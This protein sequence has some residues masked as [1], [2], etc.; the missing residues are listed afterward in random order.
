VPI[1]EFECGAC[2]ERFEELVPAGEDAPCPAC[3]G[4][5]RRVYSP[6]TTLKMGPQGADAR[7]SNTVRRAREE[8]KREDHAAKRE[9]ESGG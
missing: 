4:A 3:G 6:V 7:R 2:G 5:G 1:Y 8:K 9:R